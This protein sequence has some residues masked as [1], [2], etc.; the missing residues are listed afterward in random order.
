MENDEF[1]ISELVAMEQEFGDELFFECDEG[2]LDQFMAN[3]AAK[4]N[5][6]KTVGR[7]LEHMDSA[8]ETFNVSQTY[9]FVI[10]ECFFT[11]QKHVKKLR[12]LRNLGKS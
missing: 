3:R 8:K 1:Y 2:D 9:F 5:K 11:Q 6:I 10:F 12:S 4:V 7:I